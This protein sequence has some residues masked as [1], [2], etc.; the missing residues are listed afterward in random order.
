MRPSSPQPPTAPSRTPSTSPTSQESSRSPRPPPREPRVRASRS[1]HPAAAHPC[2]GRNLHATGAGVLETD[3]PDYS[4]EDDVHLTGS[5]LRLVRHRCPYHATR[6]LS[7]QGRRYIHGRERPGNDSGVD[8]SF[9][10]RYVLN[11]IPGSYT[12]DAL[13]ADDVVLATM[14]FTDGVVGGSI[15][16]RSASQTTE[17]ESGAIL[18]MERPSRRRTRRALLLRRR[19]DQ[20]GR[21]RRQRRPRQRQRERRVRAQQRLP[22]DV[23][24]DR[25]GRT[26]GFA[27]DPDSP[28]V[29]T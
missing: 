26:T 16:G 14:M 5:G 8:G 19:H 2:A 28:R 15:G 1:P 13:G 21:D 23:H 11:G 6:R 24:G 3:K 22:R 18:P 29:V 12:V 7:H 10:Y 25:D 20:P 9:S 4:P 17:R 27:R